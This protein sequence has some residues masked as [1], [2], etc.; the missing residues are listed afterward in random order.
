MD[1]GRYDV[2]PVLPPDLMGVYVLLP[3][4]SEV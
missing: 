1:R 2:K 4:M 3:E